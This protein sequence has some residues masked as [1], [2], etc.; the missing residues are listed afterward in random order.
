MKVSTRV[1]LAACVALGAMVPASAT[2]SWGGYHWAGN[3]S[4]V[5]I[6]V[7]KAIT[8]QWTTSVNNSISDWNA[9]NELTLTNQN[10]PAGT[11]AK[12]CSPIAGQ[13]L[14][15]NSA[16]GRRGWLGIASIW[17]QSGTL[18]ITQATTKLNDSYHDS[19]PYNSPEWR[20]LVACQEIGHDFGLDHQDET[21]DNPNLGTCMDYT[22][23]PLG[24]PANTSPNNHD[25]QEL[26]IIYN[27]D[28]GY[29]TVTAS[30][31]FGIRQVGKAVPQSSSD[32]GIGD[33]MA[34]WGRAIHR[35]AKGRP[36]VFVK[37]LGGGRKVL[38]HVFWAL[39]A[40]GNEAR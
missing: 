16:Y 25:Y 3:G 32:A 7:N 4:N 9:S 22:N 28:D 27:H 19:A 34:A 24:P 2:N 20:A 38:S 13:I 39:E 11:S 23:N 40:K 21:F 15:C 35:D 17:L 14:V 6:K 18:H 33:T 5:T 26:N 12:K 30:T 10:A 29:T 31:N 37:D 8:S 1:A 36:D